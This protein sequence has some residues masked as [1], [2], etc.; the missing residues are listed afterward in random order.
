VVYSTPPTQGRGP[1]KGQGMKHLIQHKGTQDVY[2]VIYDTKD[3]RVVAAA[4]PLH[5]GQWHHA[6]HESFDS[7]PELA[8][9]IQKD[10]D[11]YSLVAGCLDHQGV[12]YTFRNGQI[13]KSE[14][15][16]KYRL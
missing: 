2:A 14:K 8:E 3:R 7:D 12:L 5:Y 13:V 1:E 16:I 4:G 11:Q 15:G 6:Y 10:K 9:A